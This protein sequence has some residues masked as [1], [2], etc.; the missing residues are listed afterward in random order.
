MARSKKKQ[1]STLEALRVP[2]GPVDLTSYDTRAT[3]GFRGGKTTG[4]AALYALGEEVSDLQERLYAEGLSGGARRVLFVLQGMDTSGKG[5]RSSLWTTSRNLAGAI[6]PC[7]GP[8]TT[9]TSKRRA[10]GT[11]TMSP[12]LNTAPS[13]TR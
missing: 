7:P 10:S 6:S 11:S 8:Q 4:K 2:R 12:V 3:P 9:P 13:G 1:P 5:G